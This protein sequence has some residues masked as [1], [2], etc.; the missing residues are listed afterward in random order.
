[1]SAGKVAEVLARQMTEHKEAMEKTIEAAERWGV[2][3]PCQVCHLPIEPGDGG[4]PTQ[5][6]TLA[7]AKCVKLGK[8]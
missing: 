7:H 6:V 2:R 4:A 5:S 8:Q 3:P 1:M